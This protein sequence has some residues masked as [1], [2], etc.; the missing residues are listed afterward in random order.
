MAESLYLS[1][2]RSCLKSKFCYTLSGALLDSIVGFK[3]KA[4][5]FKPIYRISK[6]NVDIYI[7]ISTHTYTLTFILTCLETST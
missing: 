4:S 6:K 7:L 5:V 2:Y 3:K 1:G